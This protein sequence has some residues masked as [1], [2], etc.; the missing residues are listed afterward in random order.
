[1]SKQWDSLM[2]ALVNDHPQE[3]VEWLIDGAKYE[4]TISAELSSRAIHADGLY[5]VHLHGAAKVGFTGE[6]CW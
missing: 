4:V 1:M 5:K 2:Q 6:Y 3:F